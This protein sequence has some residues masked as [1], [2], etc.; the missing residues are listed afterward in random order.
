[1]IVD[2][3]REGLLVLDFDL[4]VKAANESFYQTF[5]V[6]PEKT[7]GRLVYELGNDQWDIPKL[8]RLLEEV[9]PENK[10]LNDFEVEHGFEDI[11]RH[12]MLLNARQMNRHKLILLAIEDV[13]ERRKAEQALHEFIEKQE[14]RI[15]ERIEERTR[16]V[17]EL[18]TRLTMAEQEERR[19]ISQV[20]HDDLQQ[21]L[22]GIQLKMKSAQRNAE[23]GRRDSLLKD[24]AEADDWLMQAVDLTRRLTVD[25][26]PPIL[27]TEGVADTLRW[28]VGH[29][30]ELHGLKVDLRAED[31][32][33]TPEHDMRLLLFQ[34][35][36]ELLFN[37][38]KHA[39][40]RRAI[41]EA[42]DVNHHLQ[43][44]VTDDGEGF[45]VETAEATEAADQDGFGL[46]SVRERLNLFG[47][48]MQI[49]SAPG[50]GTRVTVDAPLRLEP[51][52]RA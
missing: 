38:V 25:L 35:V 34:I 1:M 52:A 40:T 31:P 13:T 16:Q 48:N 18:A 28:L 5:R 43:I 39:G 8:R 6:Q 11:G 23:A 50:A 2:T 21:W 10:V 51:S 33:R 12:V 47:G 19:R 14:E 46:F 29:M 9:L 22:Y 15:E 41:V 45:D 30:E 24:F 27:K 20:L 17:R 44:C 49:E 32:L 3:V 4:R 36:R 42:R 26:S 37:V 7:V